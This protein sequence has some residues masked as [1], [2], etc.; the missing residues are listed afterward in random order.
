MLAI[1]VI[2]N[3][4]EPQGLFDHFQ[5]FESF[6]CYSVFFLEISVLRKL[7]KMALYHL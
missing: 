1:L 3:I 5:P 4:K 6:T 7:E 2:K